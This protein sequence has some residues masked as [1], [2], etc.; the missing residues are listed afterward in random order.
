M[1]RETR[2]IFLLLKVIS[3]IIAVLKNSSALKVNQF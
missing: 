2:C 3:N 1:H